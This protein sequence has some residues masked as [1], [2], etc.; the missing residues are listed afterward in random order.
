MVV[1]VISEASRPQMSMAVIPERTR[2]LHN[3]SFPK[4]VIQKHIRFIKTNPN[5]DTSPP[6]RSSIPESN[7]PNRSRTYLQPLHQSPPSSST[8]PSSPK[9]QNVPS[10][11]KKE[12]ELKLIISCCKSRTEKEGESKQLPSVDGRTEICASVEVE[13]EAEL[14]GKKPRNL[15]QK[16]SCPDPPNGIGN[17]ST[18]IPPTARNEL[19]SKRLKALATKACSRENDKKEKLEFSIS[20]SRKEI[21]DD[22]LAITG[23]KPPRRPKKRPKN[24]Q[25]IL[26]ANFPCLLL[27]EITPDSWRIP[28][29]HELT[30]R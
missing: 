10:I 14:P 8:R 13:K 26:D 3:F 4:W 16:I 1:S 9:L 27:S 5:G 18:L 21:E 11:R 22:F 2:S 7:G 20:L 6:F 15:R 23:L 17:S 12:G 19:K 29:V 25:K 28:D 30:K 24:I